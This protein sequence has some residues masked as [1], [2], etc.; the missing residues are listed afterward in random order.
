M[1]QSLVAVFKN[2]LKDK[3]EDVRVSKRLVDSAVTLITGKGMDRHM[4]HMMK[5]MGRDTPASKR[6]LEINLDHPIIQNLS[7][8]HLANVP[9]ETLNKYIVHLFE[10]AQ[11]A[12]GDIPSKPAYVKRMID[13]MQE[14]TKQ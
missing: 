14:A 5:A 7:K 2:V 8:K 1:S 3:V 11:F 12:D 10:T 4:E 6:I 13:I 9:E